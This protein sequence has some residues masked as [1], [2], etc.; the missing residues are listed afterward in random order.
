LNDSRSSVRDL[1]SKSNDDKEALALPVE[2]KC[3]STASKSLSAS[4]SVPKTNQ[5]PLF[6]MLTHGNWDA[7]IALIESEPTQAREWY[8][9]MDKA[10][11]LDA[12]KPPAILWKRLALHVAC[13]VSAP[14]GIVELLIQAYPQALE[15]PDP[16]NGSIPLHLACM[17][18]GSLPVLRTLLQARPATTKGVDARGRLPIHYAILSKANYGVVELLI[19]HD[20]ASV[21]CPDQEGKT[22]LQLAQH[23]YPA[24]SYVLGL[25]ELVWM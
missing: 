14:L 23:S 6:S 17:K 4:S 2:I 8:Y 9:G 21:L 16:H 12:T 5:T 20:P 19:R 7:A 11:S 18:G 1:L 10:P 25:L 3:G 24:G 22:P 13:V 15:L